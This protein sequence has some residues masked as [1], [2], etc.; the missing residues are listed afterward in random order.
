MLV[1]KEEKYPQI[2]FSPAVHPNFC[3]IKKY[4]DG[5]GKQ[6]YCI[7]QDIRKDNASLAVGVIAVSEDRNALLN[8]LFD[9]GM[10][11]VEYFGNE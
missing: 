7:L 11:Y 4:D 3:T 6:K 5:G 9:N 2:I 10:E 8:Y 1:M